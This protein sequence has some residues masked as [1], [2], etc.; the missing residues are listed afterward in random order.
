MPLR[1]RILR[2]ALF[3]SAVPLAMCVW[4]LRDPLPHVA[5]R[6]SAIAS[7]HETDRSIVGNSELRRIR[8]VATSGLEFD[9]IIRRHLSDSSGKLPVVV[10]LG[11]HVT[12][13]E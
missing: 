12:G 6:R 13:A 2:T 11:G 9:L 3:V 7:V 8:I 5:E 10:L 1:K 4:L